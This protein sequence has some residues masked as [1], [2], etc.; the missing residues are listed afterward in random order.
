ML[1]EA[2]V[3]VFSV[4]QELGEDYFSTLQKLAKAG[5]ENIE[6]IG[7][8]MKTYKRYS[9]E[10]PALTVRE[11]LREF[12]LTAVSAHEGT[13]PGQELTSHDW[14]SV[15]KYYEAI[16]CR[17]IVVPSAWIQG[18]EDTLRTAEQMNAVG[19][20]MKE[21]DFQFYLHN[22]AHEF[23]RI[24]DTTLFDL[25]LE[26]TDPS[27]VKFELDLAWVMRAGFDPISV[28]KKLGDRCDIVHQ[29]D[30]SRNLSG[31]LNILEAARQGGDDQLG[32]F[33]LYQKYSSPA[34]YVDLGTGAFDLEHV[35]A[36]IKDMGHVRYALIENEG[37][38]ADKL[39]SLGNDL[40]VLQKY[41]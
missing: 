32:G 5:Y 35:Y 7:F 33:Q 3:N 25:L 27:F 8:N 23:R 6:L 13:M 29:K 18:R 34:D 41:L 38:S 19:K 2:G 15:L 39:L 20:K 12:G 28:L 11:K 17:N 37:A 16:D 31:R 40:A 26:N 10:I 4:H 9:D 22:H 36:C 1:I 24:G 14:D 30:V 21:S